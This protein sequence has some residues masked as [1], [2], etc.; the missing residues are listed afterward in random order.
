[1]NKLF[2]KVIALIIL[3]SSCGKEEKVHPTPD[4]VLQKT[5]FEQLAGWNN[6][7]ISEAKDAFL[8]SCQR[9]Q[10]KQSQY[11]SNAEIKILTKDYKRICL[12][13]KKDKHENFRTF[14]EQ[15]FTPYLVSF[16]GKTNGK[17]T[18]YYEPKIR[19]SKQKDGKYKYPIHA[20]P[21]DV[22]EFNPHDFDA[23]LP[24]KRLLGRIENNK[25]IPY[26]SRAEIINGKGNIPVLLWAD[27]FVDV[28]VMHIQ[29]PAVAEFEDGSTIRISYADTNGLP[30]KGIGSILLRN[31]E[32]KAGETSMG[33][34]KK[35]LLKNPE[36]AQI[37]MKQNPRYVFHQLIGASGPLGALGIPLSAGR[38]LAVDKSFIPLGALMWL[39]TTLPDGKP[40]QRLVNAQ[41]V[42]GAIKGAIRGDFF[43]GSGGDEILDMAGKMNSGGKYYILLPNKDD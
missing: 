28:F 35:W 17:F 3:I 43:W 8:L 21:L 26:F 7:D 5:S 33:Q 39:D 40:L 29:G 4:L 31:N 30:F 2:I 22:I 16:K 19:V 27:S 15:N 11:I 13:A 10:N 36:K 25:L 34:I 12:L 42:G 24:S 14:V 18:A 37:Y 1:M 38:S 6:D 32:L 41:D 20:K 23:S 9:L